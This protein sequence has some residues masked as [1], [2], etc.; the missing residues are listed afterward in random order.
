MVLTDS[1]IAIALMNEEIEIEPYDKS[2]LGS[3]SYD[4]HIGKYLLVNMDDVIDPKKEGNWREVEIPEDGFTLVAGE[5]YLAN[6]IERTYTPNHLPDIDGK[7]SI[8]RLG[9]S[10]HQTA[11]K[12]DI[13]FNG[14]WTL[15]ITVVKKTIVYAGMKIGQIRF[16]EVKGICSKPYDA[17]TG[18]SY[19]NQEAK[20]QPS[21][22]WK[23]FK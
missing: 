22:M 17:K 8:G 20:P 3:N 5:L 7:S 9:I 6:T 12:G 13:G 23:K 15:E 1:E 14:H 16:H 18:S 19:Q 11:G 2:C 21:Q 10:I 4:V